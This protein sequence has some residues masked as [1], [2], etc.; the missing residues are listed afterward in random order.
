MS[1]IN[2][3]KAALPKEIADATKMLTEN[4]GTPLFSK[5]VPFAVHTA[6]S[7][8]SEK[9][10]RLVTNNIVSELEAL[11]T[12][13]HDL[14]QSLNLPGALQALEKPLG[15]PS[16]LVAHAEEV[17]QQDGIDRVLRSIDD[18]AKLKA[19]CTGMY[20]DSVETLRLEEEA[21]NA[22]RA[23]HG[24]IR[25]TR[26]ASREAG[27]GLYKK[28][29]EYQGYLGSAA[30]SDELVKQKVAENEHALRILGGSPHQLESFVPNSQRVKMTAK[31]EREVGKLRSVLDEISRLESRRRKK[32]DSIREKARGDD[33]T[34]EILAETATIERINPGVRI[35]PALFDPL[36][37]S[38]LARLYDPDLS[39]VAAENTEQSSLTVRLT[40]AHAAFMGSRKSDT[41]TRER[42]AALQ[43]LENAYFKYREIV[44]NLDTG[45]TFYNDLSRLL[46][47]YRDEVKEWAYGRMQEARQMEA[48][49]EAGPGVGEGTHA[50]G[51]V[52]PATPPQ[53]QQQEFEWG[54]QSLPVGGAPPQQSHHH[55]HHHQQSSSGLHSPPPQS[56]S[57]K[58]VPV[59]WSRVNNNTT[60]LPAPQAQTRMPV[61]GL[62]N[63]DA[64]TPIKF[65][66]PPPA[67]GGRK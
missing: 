21:D 52:R 19:N 35:E 60:P 50:R 41:S 20:A 14:L 33:I 11:T 23:K 37:T 46:A 31:V 34:S 58:V 63:G 16:T 62:W 57:P 48:D 54:K 9:R 64:S 56:S 51:L 42:E 36:F 8:Y 25:W 10:D 2:L 30:Q 6:A 24:L 44:G 22:A 59:D 28:A 45:R 7:I 67:K 43:A 66:G 5:L 12:K 27:A 17:R 53:Q 61:P 1:K 47:K 18:I 3:T 4:G 40:D 32:I 39:A 38:R 65:G 55:H 29:E 26:P 15:I 49:L 13:L